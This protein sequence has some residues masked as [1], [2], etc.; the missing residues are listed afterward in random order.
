MAKILEYLLQTCNTNIFV[1]P[2]SFFH[3]IMKVMFHI[4]NKYGV[5]FHD[6]SRNQGNNETSEQR[7]F[8]FKVKRKKNEKDIANT[9]NLE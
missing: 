9:V 6:G 2:L 3:G 5:I 4:S 1:L 7:E 8:L